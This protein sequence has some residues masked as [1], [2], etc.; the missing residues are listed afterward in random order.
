MI[1]AGGCTVQPSSFL[2]SQICTANIILV[3]QAEDALMYICRYINIIMNRVKA[4]TEH[5]Q[6]QIII[7]VIYNFPRTT[8]TDYVIN[9]KRN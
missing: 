7:N 9:A 4:V 1:A 2:S 5:I 6:K 8:Q 3:K